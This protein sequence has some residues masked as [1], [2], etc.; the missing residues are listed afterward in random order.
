MLLTNKK[1]TQLDLLLQSRRF[2]PGILFSFLSSGKDWYAVLLYFPSL[3]WFCFSLLGVPFLFWTVIWNNSRTST[4]FQR[5]C[6][7]CHE[8]LWV[9][10]QFQWQINKIYASLGGETLITVT[11]NSLQ[12]AD[13]WWSYLCWN[14]IFT[15]FHGCY[16]KINGLC[17]VDSEILCLRY[18]IML[19]FKL[20]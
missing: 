7:E 10:S 15:M 20:E 16:L 5:L 9:F 12:P 4:T 18:L 1:S 11:L 13:I 2:F 8:C 19:D 6:L 14:D 17:I 3:S